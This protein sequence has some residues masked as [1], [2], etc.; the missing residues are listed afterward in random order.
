MTKRVARSLTL[1]NAGARLAAE[2]THQPDHFNLPLEQGIGIVSGPMICSLA[3][4][5]GRSEMNLN[6]TSWRCQP[7]CH[8]VLNQQ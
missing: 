5:S 1:H 4:A 8:I 6:A 7:R 2:L 3:L